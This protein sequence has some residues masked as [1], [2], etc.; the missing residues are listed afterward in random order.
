MGIWV[1]FQRPIA[2]RRLVERV[3]DLRRSPATAYGSAIGA[4]VLA[5]L[6]RWAMG[7]LVITGL[8]FVTFYLAVGVAALLGGLWPGLLSVALSALAAWFFF[9]PPA[10]SFA[11]DLHGGISLGLYVFTTG[12]IVALV[13]LLHATV[14]HVL[15][16]ERDGRAI[17]QSAPNGI[18]VVNA[19][20]VIELANRSVAR[21][22]GYERRELVGMR[23]EAL[24]PDRLAGAH[25]ALRGTYMRQ[26]EPRAMGAG[27]DLRG[28]RKDGTEVPIEI[29]LTP[30]QRG[31][32]RMV[33]AIVI[34]ITERKKAA[35]QQ[36]LLVRELQHRTQNLFAVVQGVANL[37][38]SE[39]RTV[40][41]A[42]V[43]LAGRLQ[44]LAHG[45][46]MLATASWEGASLAELVRQGVKGFSTRVSVSGCDVNLNPTAT[47]N[48]AL[49]VHELATNALKHGALSTEAGRARIDGSVNRDEGV[50]TFRW[51][52]ASGPAVVDTGRR[53]FGTTI[54][55][56][57]RAPVL[58]QRQPRLRTRRS[59]LR[60]ADAGERHHPAGE[61]RRRGDG[62]RPGGNAM[63]SASCAWLIL[64]LRSR[65]VSARPDRP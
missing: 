19:H 6:A 46:A 38:L 53:G 62:P 40:A 56:Q 48:F 35:D 47:Q 39:N 55:A 57:Q 17:I 65:V 31:D 49:I 10:G 42:K 63:A 20:G 30:L 58:S 51:Q 21:I 12:F 50:F 23:L 4:V 37:S 59:A 8:P 26:P 14:D 22:F 18:I 28:R 61:R 11:L 34:D 64:A 45:Y 1:P 41:S 2:R 13:A 15:A 7:G 32:E 60:T 33:V 27:R 29:G 9:L 24:V 52:E 43:D 3:R 44:A 36:R 16:Q 5:G 54:P 25:E